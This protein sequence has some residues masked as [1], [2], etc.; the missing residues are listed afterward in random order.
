MVAHI[1]YLSTWEAEIGEMIETQSH[2]VL[3]SEIDMPGW[4]ILK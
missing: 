1:S 3:D 2:L 4:H